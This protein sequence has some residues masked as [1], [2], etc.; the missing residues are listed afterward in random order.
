[1]KLKLSVFLVIDL[2]V[3]E[4]DVVRLIENVKFRDVNN[5][6]MKELECD[7]KKIKLFMNIFVFVDKIRNYYEMYLSDYMKLFMENVIKFYKYV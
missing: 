7:K 3:F 6:F 1:M 2:R 5:E 4:D